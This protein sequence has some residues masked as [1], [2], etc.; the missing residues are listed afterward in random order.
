MVEKNLREKYST[1][2]RIEA[3]KHFRLIEVV[4]FQYFITLFIFLDF[5][6]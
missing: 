6:I 3:G 5:N 4:Y 1:N 2:I